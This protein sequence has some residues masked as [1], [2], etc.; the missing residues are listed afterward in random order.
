MGCGMAGQDGTGDGRSAF[1]GKEGQGAL[2]SADWSGKIE[3]PYLG[4]PD[5]Q[6]FM[7]EDSTSCSPGLGLQSKSNRH[8]N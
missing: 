6:R 4:G 1:T 7:M 3:W 5:A 8:Y 2:E